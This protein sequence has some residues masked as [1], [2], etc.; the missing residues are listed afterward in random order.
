M[1][2]HDVVN[3]YPN[4]KGLILMLEFVMKKYEL[5]EIR[6]RE[7]I[8]IRIQEDGGYQDKLHK[9]LEDFSPLFFKGSPYL[10]KVFFVKAG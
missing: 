7:F 1:G 6:A 3:F 9:I 8:E 5:T 4:G 10:D 2:L